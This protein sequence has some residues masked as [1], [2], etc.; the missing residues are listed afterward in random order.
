MRHSKEAE[1]AHWFAVRHLMRVASW[2]GVPS[3]R[4]PEHYWPEAPEGVSQERW[5]A[6]V[7]AEVAP[8]VGQR[9]YVV[10][11]ELVPESALTRRTTEAA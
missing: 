6:L 8:F 2:G 4:R 10:G 11:E 1:A 7:D 3:A 9:V 5:D